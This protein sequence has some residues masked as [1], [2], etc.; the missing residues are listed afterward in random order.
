VIDFN[1]FFVY[2]IAIA[3][4]F[5]GLILRSFSEGGSEDRRC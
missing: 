1:P 2:S 4:E 3:K 5:E